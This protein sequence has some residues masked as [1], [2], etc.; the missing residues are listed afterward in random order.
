MDKTDELKP[1]HYKK[2]EDTFAW[3]EKRF[4]DEQLQ[5]IAEFN[6]H[7]YL[8]RNKDQDVSDFGKIA[9]YALWIKGILEKEQL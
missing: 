6:I 7:K 4:N 8:S 5:A 2:G 3:A 9:V 1:L